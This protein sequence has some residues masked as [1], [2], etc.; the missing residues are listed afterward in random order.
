MQ[1][2]HKAFQSKLEFVLQGVSK[3]KGSLNRDI[4]CE[5]MIT[6]FPGAG[7]GNR[8]DF[9]CSAMRRCRRRGRLSRGWRRDEA[10]DHP[11]R[12]RPRH[13]KAKWAPEELEPDEG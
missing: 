1:N 11:G 5:L 2:L 12:G 10:C 9:V 3:G 13:Q 4:R 6:V 7:K 8:T